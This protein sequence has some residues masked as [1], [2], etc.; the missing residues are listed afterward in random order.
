MRLVCFLSSQ[1]EKEEDA[2][3]VR[4]TR[5]GLHSKPLPQSQHY[6]EK[7]GRD[8]GKEYR[9][10]KKAGRTKGELVNV[11]SHIIIT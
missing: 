6:R 5:P 7:R 11:E 2:V 4:P 10:G 8:G 3:N 1:R 9:G